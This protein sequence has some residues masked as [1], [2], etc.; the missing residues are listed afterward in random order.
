MD[1][2]FILLTVGFFILSAGLV[3]LCGKL[4]ES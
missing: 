1:F 4:M 2:L 3:A